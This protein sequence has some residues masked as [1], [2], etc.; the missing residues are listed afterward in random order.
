[1]RSFGG[2]QAMTGKAGDKTK[3]WIGHMLRR[4]VGYI[5]KSRIEWH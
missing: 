2:Q 4:P 1:M 5:A 3:S